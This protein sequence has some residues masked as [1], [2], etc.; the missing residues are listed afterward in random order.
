LIVFVAQHEIEGNVTN[1]TKDLFPTF[2]K[3][4]ANAFVSREISSEIRYTS[5]ETR[6][7]APTFNVI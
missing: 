4:V 1:L 3:E 5:Q 6:P 7:G 2:V